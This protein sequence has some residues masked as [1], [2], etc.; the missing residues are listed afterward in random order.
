MKRGVWLLA[1]VVLGAAGYHRARRVG[2]ALTG[3][4]QRALPGKQSALV[5]AARRPRQPTTTGLVERAA[6]TAA[7]VRDVRDGMADYRV[8]HRGPAGSTLGGQDRGESQ[9]R[10]HRRA[11]STGE[12]QGGH[13]PRAVPDSEQDRRAL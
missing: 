10:Q 5:S 3:G 2:Q 11:R 13:P 8:R 1:G 6:G 12:V 9:P 7:F 4:H